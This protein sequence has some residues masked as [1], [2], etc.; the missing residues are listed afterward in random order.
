MT[1]CPTQKSLLPEHSDASRPLLEL[2]DIQVRFR[3]RKG[4]MAPAQIIRA[5]NGVSLTLHKGETLGLVGESG[6]GKSTLAKIAA[7]LISPD[8]GNIILH[9]DSG[10]PRAMTGIV[11]G[12]IQMVFQDPFSS[13][14][15]RLTIGTSIREPL[16]VM[17]GL[18]KNERNK[19]VHE[20]LSLVGLRPE[21]ANRYPHQFSG[22]QRQRIVIARALVRRPKI[23]ICDEPVSALDASVQAQVLNLLKDLQSSFGLA[24]LFISHDLG[25]VGHMSDRV[26]V[27]YLGRIV[28]IADTR[29][30]FS[31][32]A[33]PY[34]K[35][36][37]DA[38]PTG[39]PGT[40]GK[41]AISGDPPSPLN[42]PLGCAFHP[43]CPYADNVCGSDAPSLYPIETRHDVACFHP[44][45]I[46]RNVANHKEEPGPQ[47]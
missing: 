25:V 38:V 20:V 33:H 44:L 32:P 1:D 28:E 26:A 31:N 9:E 42:P 36:L 11:P 4:F 34:T 41:A 18:S 16:D 23:I 46:P 37:L 5:V 19:R 8:S 3:V 24:M 12:A 43:R 14:N 40:R 2:H 45:L 47:T 30:L 13:L 15:P 29:E 7:G 22:G 21:H 35:V 10:T 6:C 39:I 27:M 17:G